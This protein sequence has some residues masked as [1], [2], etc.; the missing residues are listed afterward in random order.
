MIFSRLASRDLRALL[1]GCVILVS[2][3]GTFKGLP[4]WLAWRDDALTVSAEIS[5]ELDRAQKAVEG[6]ESALDSA[7][8]RLR[9]FR[10]LGSS[11]LIVSESVEATLALED[12]IREA[13]RLSMVRVGS[14]ETRMD[15][16]AGALQRVVA[17][18]SATGDIAGLTAVLHRLEGHR[19]LLAVHD[20]S[21]YPQSVETPQDAVEVLDFRF[22][23]EGLALVKQGSAGR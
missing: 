20:L 12:Q 13:A 14:V 21:V 11:L 6:V 2:V 22:T 7:E 9:R 16:A 4:A 18:V 8:A 17:N 10:D 15:T 3:I 5:A 23:V 1:G 19:I